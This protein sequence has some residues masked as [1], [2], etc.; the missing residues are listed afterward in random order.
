MK[1]YSSLFWRNS[2][3]VLIN[4]GFLVSP[5]NQ[6]SEE[7]LLLFFHVQQ[8]DGVSNVYVMTKV[9]SVIHEKVAF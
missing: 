4:Q 2:Y 7:I 6:G 8:D 1:F 3:F 9:N 5:I